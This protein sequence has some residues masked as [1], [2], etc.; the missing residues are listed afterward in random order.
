MSAPPPSPLYISKRHDIPAH[1]DTYKYYA[2]NLLQTV[3]YIVNPLPPLRP[4]G[5]Y[6]PP[7]PAKSFPGASRAGPSAAPRRRFDLSG[8]LDEAVEATKWAGEGR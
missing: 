5:G 8:R 3:L 4:Q 7:P 1:L 2:L 6:P